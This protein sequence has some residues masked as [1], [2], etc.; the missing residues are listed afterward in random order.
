MQKWRPLTDQSNGYVLRLPSRPVVHLFLFWWFFF[1]TVHGL[2][3]IVAGEFH[4]SHTVGRSSL[5]ILVACS[6]IYNRSKR[7]RCSIGQPSF[8]LM[9]PWPVSP[10]VHK[11]KQYDTA[12]LWR[13]VSSLS[14][15]L[16]FNTIIYNQTLFYY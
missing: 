6:S 3:T 16:I 14:V 9:I 15:N 7:R 12:L 11:Q 8:F 4:L 5:N 1:W 13:L 2:A 10:I